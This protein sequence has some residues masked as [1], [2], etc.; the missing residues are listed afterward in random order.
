MIK[1]SW[2]T[3]ENCLLK[4]GECYDKLF[5]NFQL[6]VT[7]IGSL[8]AQSSALSALQLLLT[9]HWY[10]SCAFQDKVSPPLNLFLLFVKLLN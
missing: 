6:C 2:N 4:L 7:V 8:C 1:L 10:N 5:M 3:T 9:L